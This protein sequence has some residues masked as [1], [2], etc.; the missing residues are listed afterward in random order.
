MLLC[1]GCRNRF[2][3]GQCVP[4]FLSCGHTFC[5]RCI[6]HSF[7]NE[8]QFVCW[9]CSTPCY[10]L[11]QTKKNLI[12]IDPKSF[13]D[14]KE[15]LL[16]ILMAE[17]QNP[18]SSFFLPRPASRPSRT[19][20]FFQTPNNNNNR[21]GFGGRSS[22]FL[23]HQLKE[24]DQTLWRM[25]TESHDSQSPERMVQNMNLAQ[26]LQQKQNQWNQQNQ[27]HQ[28]NLQN[29][30]FQQNRIQEGFQNYR[31]NNSRSSSYSGLWH[32]QPLSRIEMIID[33]YKSRRSQEHLMNSISNNTNS[34]LKL[35][36]GSSIR[37]QSAAR[38]L[39]LSRNI[40]QQRAAVVSL[41]RFPRVQ[42]NE[43]TTCQNPGCRWK[44]N[45]NIE[46]N[47]QYCGRN[48]ESKHIRQQISRSTCS[49]FQNRNLQ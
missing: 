30:H 17:V 36:R 22:N 25:R 8:N 2:D 28:L 14:A 27:Q 31:A 32:Q 29:S 9:F 19:P 1:P 44:K 24:A 48:C 4:M 6:I 12:L 18:D 34:T 11:S 43:E 45:T 42:T 7:R 38:Q 13:D 23:L 39:P 37:F 3:K 49:Q 47:Y 15:Y 40:G 10:D 46:V 35:S 16:D 21:E 5:H 20:D 33:R 41:T 26:M